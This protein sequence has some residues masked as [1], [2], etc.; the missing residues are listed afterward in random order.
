MTQFD[1]EMQLFEEIKRK[2]APIA[3]YH[4]VLNLTAYKMGQEVIYKFRFNSEECNSFVNIERYEKNIEI[5]FITSNIMNTLH[6][7]SKALRVRYNYDKN[8]LLEFEDR[9]PSPRKLKRTLKHQMELL[10][11]DLTHPKPMK[12]A[13]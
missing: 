1:Q 5:V 7:I 6:Y 9:A 3:G 8:L 2:Y 4:L 10:A 12:P 13:C 11:Y